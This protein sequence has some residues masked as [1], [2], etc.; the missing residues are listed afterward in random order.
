MATFIWYVLVLIL[1][2]ETFGKSEIINN[3]L[4]YLG[5]KRPNR[6]VRTK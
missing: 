3:N 4:F 5:T 1:N 2:W 6:L